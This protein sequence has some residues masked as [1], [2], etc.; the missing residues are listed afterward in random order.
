MQLLRDS[1]IYRPIR[2]LRIA[3]EVRKWRDEDQEKLEFYRTFIDTEDIVYDVGANI[4]RRTKIFQR[5]GARVIAVEP[6]KECAQII[7]LAF[8]NRVVVVQKALAEKEGIAEIR[9]DESSTLSSMSDDWISAVKRSGRFEGHR[10]GRRQEIKT[11]TLDR[12]LIEFGVPSF[13]KIDVEGYEFQVLR[14]LNKRVKAISIENTP[15]RI[16]AAKSCIEHLCSLGK[17][18]LNYSFGETMQWA[19]PKWIQMSEMVRFLEKVC[20]SDEEGI[21]DIYIKYL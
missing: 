1:P 2:N 15:E 9:I 12:L 6:Q 17:I 21:G 10:W 16:E 5:L 14:G 18:E 4:G 20:D 11:T 13:I 3:H 7:R 8:R 19:F